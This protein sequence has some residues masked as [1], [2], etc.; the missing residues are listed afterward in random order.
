MILLSENKSDFP[1]RKVTHVA[2]RLSLKCEGQ[3]KVK[4][5]LWQSVCSRRRHRERMFVT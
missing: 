1:N 2:M 3:V 5:G 4:G